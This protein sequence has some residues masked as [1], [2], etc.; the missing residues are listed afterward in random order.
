M[1]TIEKALII[2]AKAHEGQTDKAGL[3]YILHPLR[4]MMTMEN[5]TTMMAAILHDVIED[6]PY[7]L[8]DLWKEE[9]P[10][11]VID[12]V[13]ALTRKEKEDYMDYVKRLTV[14]PIAKVIKIADLKD[15]MNLARIESPS[16]KDIERT[17]LYRKAL[18]LVESE[19]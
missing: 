17:E 1:S 14:N 10:V 3:P 19:G 9:F 11:D 2:A 13:D 8:E 5:E 16:P 7:T 6:T 15:N 12:A 18:L 4:V